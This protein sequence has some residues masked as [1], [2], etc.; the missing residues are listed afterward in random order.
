M[1]DNLQKEIEELKAYIAFYK[2]RNK[3]NTTLNKESDEDNTEDSSKE[4]EESSTNKK[5][6]ED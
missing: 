2:K 6:L 3:I 1:E 4:T 5:I